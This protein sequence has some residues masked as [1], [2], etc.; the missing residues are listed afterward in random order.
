MRRQFKIIQKALPLVAREVGRR[1]DVEVRVGGKWAYTQG[2]IIGLPALPF[3]DSKVEILAFGYLEHEAAHDRY[4][5]AVSPLIRSPLHQALTNLFEDIRVEQALGREYPGFRVTLNLL[6][7][8]LVKDGQVFPPPTAEASPAQTLQRYL[9]YRLRGE[10]LR[11]HALDAYAQRAEIPLRAVVP[12]DL[13]TRID[14]VMGRV[15]SLQSMCEAAEL[16][17]ELLDLIEA[18]KDSPTAP[19]GNESDK[20]REDEAQQAATPAVP[21]GNS[22][23]ALLKA[24]RLETVAQL[25]WQVMRQATQ[26][27]FPQLHPRVD[28]NIRHPE[29]WNKE[30]DVDALDQRIKAAGSSE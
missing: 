28:I 3:E 16:A 6:V 23:D 25:T 12:A 14:S 4:S 24:E 5:E 11:Q 29:C 13:A 8:R 19:A 1:L 27:F 26:E 30:G 17:G 2:R 10:V 7:T 15:A 21:A 18:E 22:L 9:L 20:A